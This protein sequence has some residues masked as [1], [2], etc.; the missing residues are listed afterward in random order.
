MKKYIILPLLL[1]TSSVVAGLHEPDVAENIAQDI[2]EL[3]LRAQ[4]S[5][6]SAAEKQRL[7][8]MVARMQQIQ[9]MHGPYC[10]K[11]GGPRSSN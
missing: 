5:H 11:P 10:S 4:V 9:H 6:I 1:L 7:L 2:T 3:R 8:A